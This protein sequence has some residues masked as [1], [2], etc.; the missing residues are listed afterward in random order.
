MGDNFVLDNAS[1]RD[2]KGPE[3]RAFNEVQRLE[4]GT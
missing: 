1:A 4:P 3:F 2:K